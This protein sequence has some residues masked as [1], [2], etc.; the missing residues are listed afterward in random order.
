MPLLIDALRIG[1]TIQSA[2]KT[3]TT[4]LSIFFTLTIS[5]SQASDFDLLSS[6]EIREELTDLYLDMDE[7][8]NYI[9]KPDFQSVVESVDLMRELAS[10]GILEKSE[11]KK[12]KSFNKALKSNSVNVEELRS[13]MKESIQIKLGMIH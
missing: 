11:M 9:G 12:V 5:F 4:F 7:Q 8:I 10:R 13:L 6:S 1:L 2:L 3:K